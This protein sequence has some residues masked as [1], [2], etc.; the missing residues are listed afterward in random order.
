MMPAGSEE[1]A[2]NV[3]RSCSKSRCPRQDKGEDATHISS[4]EMVQVEQE[5]FKTIGGR[6]ESEANKNDSI[7]IDGA[8]EPRRQATKPSPRIFGKLHRIHPCPH[9]WS[10]SVCSQ[11]SARSSNSPLPRTKSLKRQESSFNDDHSLSGLLKF[12][13]MFTNGGSNGQ[14]IQLGAVEKL[15]MFGQPIRAPEPEPALPTQVDFDPFEDNDEGSGRDAQLLSH[16]NDM[17][18]G[19]ILTLSQ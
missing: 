12:N 5:N 13:D 9:V 19:T 18:Y 6:F 8:K 1:V 14:G 3:R 16:Y 17:N 11:N 15:D 10:P 2:R 4:Q 7:A